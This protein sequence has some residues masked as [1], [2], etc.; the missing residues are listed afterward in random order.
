VLGRHKYT[1]DAQDGV[2]KQWE[3]AF[4]PDTFLREDPTLF[5]ETKVYFVGLDNYPYVFNALLACAHLLPDFAAPRR[6]FPTPEELDL[7]AGVDLQPHVDRHGH[8]RG[9]VFSLGPREGHAGGGEVHLEDVEELQRVKNLPGAH[10]HEIT[11]LVSVL[12]GGGGP[13]RE[14][15][16]KRGVGEC[17]AKCRD[18]IQ[19]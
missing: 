1:T 16:R 9:V 19:N 12:L 4:L 5:L 6:P 8:I 15:L 11:G 3:H 10:G 18:T 13:A 7:V 17:V 2:G 14:D